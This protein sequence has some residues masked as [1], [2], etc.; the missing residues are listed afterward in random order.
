METSWRPRSAATIATRRLQAACTSS[1]ARQA[2]QALMLHSGSGLVP[3]SPI[4]VAAGDDANVTL[5][6]VDCLEVP[7]CILAVAQMRLARLLCQRGESRQSLA[8]DDGTACR[9]CSTGQ[10]R[11]G[12]VDKARS[13]FG[14]PVGYR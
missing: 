8:D 1:L 10:I 7:G 2:S 4:I 11:L 9:E 5:G 14:E 13:W 12:A 6:T 3:E